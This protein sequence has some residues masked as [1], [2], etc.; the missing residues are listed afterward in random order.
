M[1]AR[2]ACVRG[3]DLWSIPS[4]IAPATTA[5]DVAARLGIEP[6]REVVTFCNTGHWAATEWFALSE[7][8]GLPDVK[9]YPESMVGYAQSGHRLENTPGLVGNLLRQLRGS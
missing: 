6:A 9:L 3:Q 7:L 5:A 4:P 1:A 2:L 8:A